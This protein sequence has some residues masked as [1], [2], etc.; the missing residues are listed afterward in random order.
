LKI[1]LA[2]NHFF[3]SH[4]A[5]TEQYVLKLA[6]GIQ[7]E[8]DNCTV[9]IPHEIGLEREYHFENIQVLTFES[10]KINL[11][12]RYCQNIVP[13]EDSF[14]DVLNRLNPDIVHF[15]NLDSIYTIHH[16]AEVKKRGIKVFYTPHLAGNI[17]PKGDFIQNNKV[18]CNQRLEVSKCLKCYYSGSIKDRLKGSSIRI[19][20]FLNLNK[21]GSRIYKSHNYISFQNWQIHQLPH[22]TDEVIS[23]AP[24]L[25][26]AF[27]INQVP[28]QLIP[29]NLPK[30]NEL[31]ARTVTNS[32]I[33]FVG[34]AYPI[35]GLLFLL[36]CLEEKDLNKKLSLTVICAKKEESEYYLKCKE[37]FIRL[38]YTHWMEE[39]SN[40]EVKA[41]IQ[42]H[43]AL[44]APS[45]S[46]VRPLAVMESISYGIPVI[47]SNIPAMEDLI[48]DGENG[49][50]FNFNNKDELGTLLIQFTKQEL[51]L[52]PIPRQI[53]PTISFEKY[54]M[55][56]YKKHFRKE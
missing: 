11:Q 44:V 15:H 22:Y 39:I 29:T 42:L 56:L 26:K 41:E 35:K 5:G 30:G 38:G 34:R 17:C 43:S 8:G 49:F 18:L 28:S 37:K 55:D 1:V 40:E 4:Q 32:S 52:Q 33:V 2:T 50:L 10:K 9:L 48:R 25:Q 19:I 47:A 31:K 53:S 46:E 3:P 51:S 36:D 23:I 14:Q 45:R 13:V 54:T 24:W 20:R 6:K 12:N 21:I 7:A 27:L 16:F